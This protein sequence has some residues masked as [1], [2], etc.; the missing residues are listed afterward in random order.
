MFDGVGFSVA[1]AVALLE[2]SNGS[3]D[4]SA[5]S[6]QGKHA[7][8]KQDSLTTA[9]REET[10]RTSP[11]RA[12]EQP[13][14]PPPSN[15][16]DPEAQMSRMVDDLV[17]AQEGM[18][19]PTTRTTP[20]LAEAFE[21]SRSP[22]SRAVQRMQSLSSLWDES[23]TVP[24]TPSLDAGTKPLGTPRGASA[25]ARE[26]HSR[27][28]SATSIASQT[29][30]RSIGSSFVPTPPLSHAVP[31]KTR[32]DLAGSTEYPTEMHSPLLFGAGG[33]LWSTTPRRS[34]S[35]NYTPPNGQGG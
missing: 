18:A 4:V 22:S 24:R 34:V 35:N 25:R 30:Y 23:P 6:R 31:Q 19:P 5:L 11:V 1:N 14:V 16:D 33:G 28:N 10:I 17:G 32:T 9:A 15:N 8:T 12:R 3:S 29:P 2:K 21:P 26:T 7:S 27:N 13:R 20:L